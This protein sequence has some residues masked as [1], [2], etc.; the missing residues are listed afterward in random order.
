M[1]SPKKNTLIF[2]KDT[3]SS[4]FSLPDQ[5]KSLEPGQPKVPPKKH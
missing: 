2:L 5:E 4:C 3:N 1:E